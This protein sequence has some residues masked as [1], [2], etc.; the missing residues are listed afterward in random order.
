MVKQAVVDGRLVDIVALR[1]ADDEMLSGK[2]NF[3]SEF[4]LWWTALEGIGRYLENTSR[5]S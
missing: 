3:V 1:I 2:E 5:P 4:C